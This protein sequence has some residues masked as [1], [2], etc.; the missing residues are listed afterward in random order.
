MCK[1]LYLCT[2]SQCSLDTEFSFWTHPSLFPSPGFPG[3]RHFVW[4]SWAPVKC[5]SCTCLS[6]DEVGWVAISCWVC[7]SSVPHSMN[8][9]LEAL[10]IILK[11]P[12]HCRCLLLKCNSQPHIQA[13][14]IHNNAVFYKYKDWADKENKIQ[15]ADVPSVPHQNPQNWW[16]GA[17][18]GSGVQ[19]KKIKIKSS[20]FRGEIS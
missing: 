9:S 19:K 1:T 12:I 7:C 2:I 8:D 20:I 18:A 16:M 15:T 4:H 14:Q 6:P 5:I 10:P 3:W 13:W 11:D 17:V